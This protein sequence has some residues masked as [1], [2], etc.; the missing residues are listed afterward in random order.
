MRTELLLLTL[1]LRSMMDEG[2]D[3][4]VCGEP[5]TGQTE[6]GCAGS[7]GPRALLQRGSF[8]AVLASHP[9]A[10]KPQRRTEEGAGPLPAPAGEIL[11]GGGAGLPGLRA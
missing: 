11:G 10:V 2:R 7:P 9:W 1:G 3:D 4:S 8:S 5:C 6:G